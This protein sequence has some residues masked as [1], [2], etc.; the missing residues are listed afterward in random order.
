MTDTQPRFAIEFRSGTYFRNV[1]DAHGSSAADALTFISRHLAETYLRRLPAWVMANGGCVVEIPASPDRV[2]DLEALRNFAI[3]NN[4]VAFSH[5]VT[6]A[7]AGEEWA[8]ARL[9]A[10]LRLWAVAKT[11]TPLTATIDMMR[12]TD[13]TRPDG[14]VARGIEV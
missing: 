1:D 3:T 2:A 6:A 8:V 12:S 14:A 9:E 7:L 5:L 4:E 10:P 13:T 11:M